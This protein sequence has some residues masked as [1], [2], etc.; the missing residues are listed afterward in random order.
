MIIKFTHISLETPR[1]FFCNVMYFLLFFY[2]CQRSQKLVV[3]YVV[4]LFI[5]FLWTFACFN[6][7]I[8][9]SITGHTNATLGSSVYLE[10][11]I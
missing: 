6:I 5:L 2:T 11:Q 10:A 7:S 9:V 4:S 1:L 3:F 8:T